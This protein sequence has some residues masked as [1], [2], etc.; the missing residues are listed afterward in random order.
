M[1]LARFSP[2]GIRS[3]LR[4]ASVRPFTT[5]RFLFN[6]QLNK[7]KTPP[8]HQDIDINSDAYKDHPIIK[9][10]PKSMKKYGKRFVN[11]PVSHLT[12]FVILHEFTAV[13]PFLGLWYAFH[14]FGFLP[15]D[16]PS[17]ILVKGSGVIETIVSIQESI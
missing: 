3:S 9:R 7:P 6:N 2:F 14:S 12:A 16:I 5:T 11:A 17:W 1:I 13:A 15:A 10:L 8:T 4:V